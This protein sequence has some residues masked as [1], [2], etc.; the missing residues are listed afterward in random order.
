M[1][2]SNDD[3]REH[4]ARLE[5]AQTRHRDLLDAMD[6][7]MLIVN[8]R[9]VIVEVNREACEATQRERAAV[10]GSAAADLVVA[11][12]RERFEEEMRKALA[13][14]DGH[15]GFTLRKTGGDELQVEVRL[16]PFE[17]AGEPMVCMLFEDVSFL[18]ARERRRFVEGPSSA[19]GTVCEGV[20]HQ[21]NNL[22]ARVMGCA[23]DADELGVKDT[24]AQNL[25]TIINTCEEGSRIT[26]R[27]LSYARR[28]P[29]WRK[30][31][32]PVNILEHTL[33][34]MEEQLIEA[35]VD[36]VRNYRYV[37]DMM[38]DNV[39]IGQ[40]FTDLIRN[41]VDAMPQGGRLSVACGT[42]ADDLV[43][44]I[45]DTGVGIDPA[46]IERMFLPF[47]GTK[48]ALSGSET[49]GMGLGLCVC[50]GIIASH[51]GN[52][53]AESTPD[54]GTTVTVRIPVVQM[55]APPEGVD[56]GGGNS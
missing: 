42:E 28:R 49:P 27:L 41:A 11:R 45:S 4:L 44:R 32:N 7:G 47:V 6:V 50:Q 17:S 30:L 25:R 3:L 22:L 37:P 35:G 51:H 18:G 43:V 15:A 12:E 33:Q 31:V 34:M 26:E 52:I 29:L 38:L 24:V 55:E 19:V 20:A 5:R 56:A 13:G 46:S 1:S 14:G 2:E 23:E 8:S 54:E 40:V 21:F 16:R 39:Q 48:G 9:G 36:V 10:T 53:S